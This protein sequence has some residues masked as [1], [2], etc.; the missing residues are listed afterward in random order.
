MIIFA[1]ISVIVVAMFDVAGGRERGG[2][3]G[4]RATRAELCDGIAQR[5]F[6]CFRPVI[7][8][9]NRAGCGH[10]SFDHPDGVAQTRSNAASNTGLHRRATREQQL[11]KLRGHIGPG[12]VDQF[13]HSPE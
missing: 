8:D 1:M 2:G 10:L 12:G 6:G 9:A 4:L 5:R 11:P 3:N 13:T 7:L